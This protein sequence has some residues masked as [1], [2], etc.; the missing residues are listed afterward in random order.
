MDLIQLSRATMH[1][2]PWLTLC[3][4]GTVLKHRENYIL[5]QAYTISGCQVTV[6]AQTFVLVLVIVPC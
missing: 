6:M 4:H 3:L 2:V 5:M 1:V